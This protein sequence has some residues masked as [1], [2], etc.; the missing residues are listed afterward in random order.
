MA[1]LDPIGFCGD[2]FGSYL[3]SESMVTLWLREGALGSES[4]LVVVEASFGFSPGLGYSIGCAVGRC[5]R[6]A[7]DYAGYYAWA[8][9]PFYLHQLML[10]LS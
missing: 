5:R 1:S 4:F 10:A 8:L 6:N 7:W 3:P 9:V 2:I